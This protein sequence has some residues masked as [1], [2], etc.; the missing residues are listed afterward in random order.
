MLISFNW[1]KSLKTLTWANLM[2][3]VKKQNADSGRYFSKRHKKPSMCN[4]MHPVKGH[5]GL[6]EAVV[7]HIRQSTPH[8]FA[9]L[10]TGLFYHVCKTFL[11]TAVL[12]FRAILWLPAFQILIEHGC[13]I[14]NSLIFRAFKSKWKI[15]YVPQRVSRFSIARP[16]N[17]SLRPKK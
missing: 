13:Q 7:C 17:K 2:T 9:G 8:L 5:S 4:G 11:R 12:F 14:G 6:L 15:G 10:Y 16:W 3:P 1:F